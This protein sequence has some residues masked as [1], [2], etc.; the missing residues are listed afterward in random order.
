[1]PQRG[2]NHTH[3]HDNESVVE[4]SCRRNYP[5]L[6]HK[7]GAVVVEQNL[8]HDRKKPHAASGSLQNTYGLPIKIN[9]GK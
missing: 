8:E 3:L 4:H 7:K 1:M 5:L 2:D 9:Q 6:Q